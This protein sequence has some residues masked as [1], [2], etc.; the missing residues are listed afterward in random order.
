MAT[1]KQ[2]AINLWKTHRAVAQKLGMNMA[3]GGP[4]E[5][6][7]ALSSD[8]LL[9]GLVKI[10]TDKGVVTDAELN[11]MYTSLA[12]ADYPRPG[13]VPQDP[14]QQAPDPDLGV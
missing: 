6:I 13:T 2:Y 11:A 7:R 10:L 5:R 4:E 14:D 3:V 12:N 1:V 8:V 9:A